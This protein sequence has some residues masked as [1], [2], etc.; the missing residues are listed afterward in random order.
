MVKGKAG[1]WT[2]T[3]E[4]YHFLEDAGVISAM[5][6]EILTRHIRALVKKGRFETRNQDDIGGD[7]DRAYF[8]E[9]RLAGEPYDVKSPVGRIIEAIRE[10]IDTIL[11]AVGIRTARGV[12]RDIRTGKIHDR[13]GAPAQ[14]R[15]EPQ[16]R[17]RLAAPT[18]SALPEHV[19]ERWEAARGVPR[20][21]GR[22]WLAEKLQALKAGTHHFPALQRIE[23]KR[24]R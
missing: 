22:A 3:H 7:E 9:T 23:D 14:G 1:M 15:R 4:F 6:R 12:M 20:R 11:N 24:L 18:I 5:D 8:A 10:I 17:Y 13:E 2:L 19:R 16:Y 21:P